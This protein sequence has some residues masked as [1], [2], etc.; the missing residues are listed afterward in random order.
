M[1]AADDTFQYKSVYGTAV[2][3]ST[4]MYVCHGGVG[5]GEALLC[6][7]VS[8]KHD[9]ADLPRSVSS[10]CDATNE[11]L[12]F[13]FVK[14]KIL[15]RL[16]NTKTLFVVSIR[17]M[18]LLFLCIMFPVALCAR[19]PTPAAPLARGLSVSVSFCSRR[20]SR[21]RGCPAVVGGV[22]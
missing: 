14:I 22:A 19:C 16:Q 15:L 8:P 5:G 4:R 20:V 2:P 1:T 6:V 10:S 11:C 7:L 17:G 18:P 3:S 13:V 21:K 9:W 12:L